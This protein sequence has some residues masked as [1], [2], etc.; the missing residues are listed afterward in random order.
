MASKTKYVR[1]SIT[2]I[3]EP[4]IVS[5]GFS[6]KYP[7]YRR[8]SEGSL[9]ILSVIHSKWGGALTLEFGIVDAGDFHTSWGE[10][11]PEHS[12]EIGHVPLDYRARLKPDNGDDFF[13][14][15]KIFTDKD[16][17]DDI[18]SSIA[19]EVEQVD[20]WLKTGNAG[21]NISPFSP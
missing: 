8:R 1:Q 15:D 6:G 18:I 9:H 20:N 10:I 7:H 11:V 4:V 16:K 21:R 17:C 12:I 13:S 19:S 2:R 14:Y 5:A 3:L